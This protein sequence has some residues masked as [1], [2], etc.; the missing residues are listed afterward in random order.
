MASIASFDEHPLFLEKSY[1]IGA[2]KNTLSLLSPSAKTGGKN[3]EAC[4]WKAV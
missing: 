3:K 2:N 4:L 1:Q